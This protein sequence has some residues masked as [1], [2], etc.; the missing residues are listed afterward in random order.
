[1]TA[2]GEHQ[3][4][5]KKHRRWLLYSL[6]LGLIWT[7]FLVFEVVMF[8]VS[9]RSLPT[10]FRIAAVVIP[11]VVL[12]GVCLILVMGTRIVPWRYTVFGPYERSP[13]PKDFQARICMNVAPYRPQYVARYEVGKDGIELTF[14]FGGRAFLTATSITAIG[15]AA[16]RTYVV[17]HDSP[18]IGGPLVVSQEVGEALLVGLGRADSHAS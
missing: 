14:A 12:V 15:P 11:L 3:P 18:E 9:I 10:P 6:A 4:I 17:E 13:R 16:W 7:S 5:R 1:M 8:S 2:Q